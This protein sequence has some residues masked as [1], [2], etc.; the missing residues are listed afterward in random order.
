[1]NNSSF[2]K[3]LNNLFGKSISSSRLR[4]IFSSYYNDSNLSIEERR[5]NANV[6]AHSL[7]TQQTVYTKYSQKLHEK[8]IY[9]KKIEDENKELRKRIK[10]LE[11]K[12]S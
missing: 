1:M 6:M 3:F 2:T 8:D 9:I 11:S 4:N 7:K 10:L 5:K 12:L